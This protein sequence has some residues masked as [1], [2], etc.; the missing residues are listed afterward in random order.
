MTAFRSVD[1]FI[2]PINDSGDSEADDYGRPPNVD[3]DDNENEAEEFCPVCGS[4]VPA[5]A[6]RRHLRESHKSPQSRISAAA[7]K[8]TPPTLPAAGIGPGADPVA[9][10]LD[11]SDSIGMGSSVDSSDTSPLCD[12]D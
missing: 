6:L 10:A 5:S 2:Q 8:P 11:T 9:V 12:T 3:T 4:L 1:Y 7:A